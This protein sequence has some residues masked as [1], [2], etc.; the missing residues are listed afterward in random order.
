M[1]IE[2][3]LLLAPADNAELRRHPLLAGVAT[4]TQQLTA[5]YF[6]TPDLHLL[7]HGAGLRVRK[8]DGLW[9]QTMKAGGSVQSGLH[10][11]NEWQGPVSRPWPQLGKLRK[12]IGNEQH[13]RE[14]LSVKG[15]NDRLEALFEVVV[16]REIWLLSYASSQI[17]L[18][19]DCGH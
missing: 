2:L 17:E 9:V 18:V 3:K 13:W 1:E 8:E 19:L 11:R 10:Q 4:R 6:D 5:H 7:R 14:V 12:L 15:L 16:Q